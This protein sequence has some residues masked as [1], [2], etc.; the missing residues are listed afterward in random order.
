MELISRFYLWHTKFNRVKSVIGE[1]GE[2]VRERITKD[3]GALVIGDGRASSHLFFPTEG[4]GRMSGHNQWKLQ[5]KI[6]T[7]VTVTALRPSA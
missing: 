1:N 6:H 3:L 2:W 7:C 4:G 5:F